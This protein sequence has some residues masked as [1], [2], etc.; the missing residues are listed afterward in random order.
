MGE[1]VCLLELAVVLHHRAAAALFSPLLAPVAHL[2]STRDLDLT[3]VA[4]HLGAGAALLDDRERARAYYQQ[5]LEVCQKVRSRSELA[6]TRLQL[7][8]LLLARYPDER[9]EAMAH[10]DFAIAEFRGMKMQ[11]ALDRALRSKGLLHA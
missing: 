2:M 4:R 11:P 1:V 8:E 10:L 6:L 7:A 9:A 3:C 5:A